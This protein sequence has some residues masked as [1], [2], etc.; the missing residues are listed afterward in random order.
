[1]ESPFQIFGHSALERMATAP[2]FNFWMYQTISPYISGKILE[3][4]S[5]IGNISKHFINNC[6]DISLSDFDDEYINVLKQRFPDNKEKIFKLD[7][8][9]IYFET[10]F[11]HLNESFDS[12]F[13]LN[14]LEHIEDDYRA[15]ENCKLLLKPGGRLLVLVPCYSFLYSEIDKLLGHYKRYTSRSLNRVLTDNKLK[16]GNTFHFNMLGIA[17]WFWNKIFRQSHISETKM[18]LYNRLVPVARIID[19]FT[20][21]KIGLSVISIANKPVS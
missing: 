9:D 8:A 15:I 12:I 6:R 19:K 13:L 3:V 18:K 10:N 4:G 17:G 1:M 5:G 14:V 11:R 21:R 2:E 16:I 7:L 20:F